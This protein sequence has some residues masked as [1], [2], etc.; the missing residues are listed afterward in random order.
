MRGI[1]LA[2]NLNKLMTS[3]YTSLI[4]AAT[5][6]LTPLAFAYEGNPK[7][8]E[9]SKKVDSA[10]KSYP[11]D[12]CVVSGKKL[13]VMGQPFVFVHEGQEV[14]LCCKECRKDFDK[15]PAKYLKMLQEKK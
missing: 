2:T 13:G 5:F 7:V 11:L 10:V 8:G 15:E 14:K 6:G 3:K 9:P 1:G 12:T 4:A